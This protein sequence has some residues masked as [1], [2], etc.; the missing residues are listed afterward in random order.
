MKINY[1][2]ENR[3]V[4]ALIERIKL[5]ESS[6]DLFKILKDIATIYCFTRF[7]CD[8]QDCERTRI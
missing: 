5:G 3:Q 8:E 1:S 4:N 2:G 7:G 6:Y